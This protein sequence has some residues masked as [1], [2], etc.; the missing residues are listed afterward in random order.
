MKRKS[1]WPPI[2]LLLPNLDVLERLSH[3]EPVDAKSKP[4]LRQLCMFDEYP[5][6]TPIE[7]IKR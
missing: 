3:A 7:R 1:E 5:T 6:L 4:E 2:E